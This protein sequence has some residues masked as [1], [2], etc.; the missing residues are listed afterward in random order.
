MV[1]NSRRSTRWPYLLRSTFG[2]DGVLGFESVSS[3]KFPGAAAV[4][5]AQVEGVAA[6]DEVFVELE[7]ARESVLFAGWPGDGTDNGA[8]GV[9]AWLW[10]KFPPHAGGAFEITFDSRKSVSNLVVRKDDFIDANSFS[11][12][13]P[14]INEICPARSRSANV[15]SRS[16]A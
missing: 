14:S 12:G 4:M 2:G 5:E 13:T 8:D 6:L 9:E 10:V 1:L 7:T 16:R 3:V 11:N 15:S